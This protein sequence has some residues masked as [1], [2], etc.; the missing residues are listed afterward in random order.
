MVGTGRLLAPSCVLHYLP[1][2]PLV[3]LRRGIEYNRKSSSRYASMTY[4]PN[5]GWMARPHF[6]FVE[7]KVRRALSHNWPKAGLVH[8]PPPWHGGTSTYSV[9]EKPRKMI[10][11]LSEELSQASL[12]LYSMSNRKCIDPIKTFLC[13]YELKSLTRSCTVRLHFPFLC[14]FIQR[15]QKKKENPRFLLYLFSCSF[16]PPL[17]SAKMNTK[18]EE[19]W[20]EGK[21]RLTKFLFFHVDSQT[22]DWLK[23]LVII[24]LL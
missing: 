17:E 24:K 6:N 19:K 3:D 18:F 1:Y 9:F 8:P 14:S 15:V 21:E 2:L 11:C 20:T 7:I 12:W 10:D 16:P 5:C 13:N 23:L 22:C 4:E